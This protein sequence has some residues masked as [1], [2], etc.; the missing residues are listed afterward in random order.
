MT[1]PSGLVG[2]VDELDRARAALTVAHAGR[3]QVL[4]ISGE[5]GIGKS[6]LAEE[7]GRLA[8]EAGGRASWG[9]GMEGAPPYWLW[10]QALP[11]LDL[12]SDAGRRSAFE[13]A[14]A[15]AQVLRGPLERSPTVL[16]FDDVHVADEASL[17]LV[18]VLVRSSRDLQLLIVA[19]YSGVMH[20]AVVAEA[21][22]RLMSR[23]D[24]IG[25]RGLDLAEVRLFYEGLTGRQCPE[26]LAI[27]LFEASEGHPLFLREAIRSLDEHGLHRPDESMG[28]RVP[29]GARALLRR[30]LSLLDP[31]AVKM[32]AIAS[33]FGRRFNVSLLQEVAPKDSSR[34]L[35]LL[36]EAT[37]ADVIEEVGGYGDYA[38][39]QVLLREVLYE[40]LRAS[41]RMSVH[42]AIADVLMARYGSSEDEHVGEIAHHLFKAAQAAD[43]KTTL[44]YLLRAGKAA[45]SRGVAAEATR[46]LRRALKVADL[47]GASRARRAEITSALETLEN[48]GELARAEDG[49]SAGL[50][51]AYTFRR[52][53]DYWTI[54]YQSDV[55]RVKDSKGMRYL[56]ILLRAPGREIHALELA[57]TVGGEQRRVSVSDPMAEGL[58]VMSFSEGDPLLDPKAKAA[59]KERIADLQEEMIDAEE[60]N[61]PERAARARAE[62]DALAEHLAGSVGLGGRDRKAAF[63]AEKARLSV[64][65]ALRSALAK[66]AS[67]SP[68]LGEHLSATVKTGYF[69]A[70]TPDPRAPIDWS[71]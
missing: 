46:H 30:R 49:G 43:Q 60:M 6:R 5:S 61:D 23:S 48:S 34:L 70:Y 44:E 18:D 16:I 27:E 58:P 64:T 17:Q 71:G 3:T 41:Q 29:G 50:P 12:A 39:T 31:E 67:S 47:A 25:L 22:T 21:V 55:I 19:T 37:D 69:C 40:D 56:D 59:F 14:Q 20:D 66:I 54:E 8:E 33:V 2:R 68:G 65:K 10:Q 1:D 24:H 9:T 62:L 42:A 63:E 35:E 52:E 11:E 38:F 15:V 45:A 13:L 57:S 36:G 53:G 4:L 28:F 26:E 7:I 32:L 51:Q